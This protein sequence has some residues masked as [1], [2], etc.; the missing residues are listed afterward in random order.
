MTTAIES[1]ATKVATLLTKPDTK[2]ADVMNALYKVQE[3]IDLTGQ[4]ETVEEAKAVVLPEPVVVTSAESAALEDLDH[5]LSLIRWPNARK[6]LTT[7]QKRSL[8]NALKQEKVIAK[9]LTRIEAQVK[10][11]AWN[12]FDVLA[13]ADG[14][15]NDDTQTDKHGYYALDGTF[16]DD[17]TGLELKRQVSRPSANLTAEDLAT[18]EADGVITHAEYLSLTAPARV[19]DSTKFMAALAKDRSL[20]FRL[21]KGTK[22]GTPTNSMILDG[23]D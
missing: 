20:V 12:H 6:E 13:E 5:L 23:K 8:L 15:I 21:A 4:D 9:L 14:Q 11:A 2:W 17:E 7:L 16:K 18:L 10:V 19:V 3:E 22:K 1:A